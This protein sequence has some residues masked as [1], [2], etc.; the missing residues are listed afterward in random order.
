MI[1][2]KRSCPQ[3]ACDEGERL[4]GCALGYEY[5][6]PRTNVTCK[7]ES[8]GAASTLLLTRRTDSSRT[9]LRALNGQ[10]AVTFVRQP[11]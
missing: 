6:D 7:G 2:R 11:A 5:A 4:H 9:P 3:A 10:S 8:L 1:E